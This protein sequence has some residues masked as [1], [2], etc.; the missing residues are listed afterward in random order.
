MTGRKF[1]FLF[2]I[3]KRKGR[4]MDIRINK[5]TL[6][7]F[8]GIKFLEINADGENLNIYG[9]N[10]TGK[11]TVFDAFTWLLFG[12]DSLGRSDFGIKT[13]DENGNP[14]HN[15]EH[16]AECE[17]AIDNSILTLKKVYAEKWT[18]KRGSADTEFSGHETKYFINEVPST[19]K[20]YEQKIAMYIDENL[21]KTITNPLYFNEHL[22]WQDRRAILLSLCEGGIS[23]N[24]VLARS[25]EFLPLLDEL[26]GRTVQEYSKIIKGKQ[27]AINDEL[28]AIPQ[29]ISE[30]TLA[31]PETVATVDESEK[32]LLEQSI[33]D[34]NEEIVAIKN[35]S[36]VI[37]VESELR[38]LREKKSRLEKS[39]CDV[40]LIDQELSTAKRKR[41]DARYQVSICEHKIHS[42]DDAILVYT[43]TADSLRKEWCEVNEKQYTDS[44]MCPTCGQA[45]PDEQI[46]AAKAKF[47]TDRA[48]KLDSI[49]E[50]GKRAKAEID[51]RQKQR[52][53]L[54]ANLDELK[55]GVDDYTKEIENLTAS[56]E[57]AKAEFNAVKEKE[58]D[59]VNQS[60]AELEKNSQNATENVQ[61]RIYTIQEQIAEKRAKLSEIDKAIASRDIAERQKQRIADLSADEKRLAMEYSDLEKTAFLIERFTKY[62]VDLLSEE[63]NGHFKYA[64]FKLFEEQI[65]GGIAEC[66]EVCFNGVSYSDLNNAARIFVGIDIINTLSKLYGKY[67]VIITD[68]AE[69]INYIPETISQQIN[70]YVSHDKE[71]VIKK[72]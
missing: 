46:E 60:I 30:A 42:L 64:K 63:I 69:S 57:K 33:A 70:L 11:T 65:N 25:P 27:T 39:M 53:E 1:S 29:R 5:L 17:L 52:L 7:N 38:E 51:A 67:A 50:K 66:C 24:D 54:V 47:N 43:Q 23:D 15:L 58:I 6:Q 61:A 41:D 13:Q 32:A 9:D 19:K 48:T 56:I 36:G 31:I 71:L 44:G 59:V 12:K 21:F 34:L 8:K 68:N 26:K 2:T 4:T 62:K 55:K 45:L 28:K 22:K 14:I 16:T 35:G 10:A 20:E 3:K 18:K 72:L 49:T 40:S 37:G